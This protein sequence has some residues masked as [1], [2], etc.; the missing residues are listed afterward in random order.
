[1]KKNYGLK[2]MALG[3]CAGLL[4]G[5]LVLKKVKDNEK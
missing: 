2:G 3:I 1:M 5:M 4:I